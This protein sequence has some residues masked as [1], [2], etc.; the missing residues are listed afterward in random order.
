MVL[1]CLILLNYIIQKII[2]L[3][4]PLDELFLELLR[5][6]IEFVSWDRI[7]SLVISKTYS[8]K[9]PPSSISYRADTVC[10]FKKQW[11]E[12]SS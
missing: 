4:M 7:T 9:M 11:P 1:S 10:K 6:V 12:I 3:S 2:K 8:L 5:K